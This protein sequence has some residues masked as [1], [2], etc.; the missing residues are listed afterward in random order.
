MQIKKY[1]ASTIREAISKV[2]DILGP[3]AMIISTKRVK[4]GL[5]SHLFEV[6]AIPAGGDD[7]PMTATTLG[8]VKSELMSIKDMIYLLNHSSGMIEKLAMNPAILNFY[9]RLIRNGVREEYA[10]IFLKEPD[11]LGESVSGTSVAGG[12]VLEGAITEIKRIIKIGDPFETNNKGPV[13]AVFVGTTG[14]GK[15]TTVAKIAAELML[16]RRKKVGLLSIDNYRIG[17]LEQIRTYANILGIP[18]FQ[19][20][21][22]K[23]L[24]FAL[25]RMEGRDVI[26][27][28]T[29]GQS[30][31]DKA[32]MEELRKIIPNDL[33]IS[34]H[35]LLSV[36]TAASE[37]HKTASNFSP[38]NFQTY[39]FTKI[40]ESERCGSI[41]NQLMTRNLPISY[42]TTG[43][44]VP[45]DIEKANRE[46]LVKLFFH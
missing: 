45:E 5:D 19:A 7:S 43:Q 23:D 26:L 21:N 39:I 32:R 18:C 16:K 2:K 22:K 42:I 14:V 20:F 46:R 34:S 8:E 3:E 4:D 27:I 31:Y 12:K 25:G 10:R 37:M 40:D 11:S 17:A 9:T 44:N 33:P 41:V 38:L 28:D 15:T 35:L 29:A 30:Q 36:A 1:R 6:S 13:V 24:Y